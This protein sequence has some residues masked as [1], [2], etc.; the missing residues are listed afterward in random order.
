MQPAA[1]TVSATARGEGQGSEQE[2]GPHLGTQEPGYPK[3]GTAA[4]SSATDTETR[5]RRAPRRN[6]GL[7]GAPVL[8]PFTSG[9]STTRR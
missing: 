2:E 9:P 4:T 1:T 3:A 5:S 7:E 6:Y 8:L